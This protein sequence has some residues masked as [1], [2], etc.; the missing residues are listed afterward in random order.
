MKQPKGY[1]LHIGVNHVDQKH[2]KGLPDLKA[3]VQDA[4]DYKQIV[5]DVFQY[6]KSD[7]LTNEKATAA[8]VSAKLKEYAKIVEPGS[9]FFLSYSGHGGLI[10]NDYFY[11]TNDE[12]YDQTWCLYDRQFLDDEIFDALSKFDEG[13]RILV[14][15]DSCHSGTVTRALKSQSEDIERSESQNDYY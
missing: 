1:S 9:I 3:A 7:I 10:Q 11:I 14:I 15:S 13:V 12:E 2:Y 4:I 8:N 6:T 5:Q